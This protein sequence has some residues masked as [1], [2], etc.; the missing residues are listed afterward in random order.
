VKGKDAGTGARAAGTG[1][2]IDPWA[3]GGGDE[4]K[5]K[6][7]GRDAKAGGAVRDAVSD[8]RRGKPKDS[9]VIYE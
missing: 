8:A 6:D 2:L 4:V 9:N 1:R 7:A 3:V 5:G